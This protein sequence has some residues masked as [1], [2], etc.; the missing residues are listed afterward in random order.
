MTFSVKKTAIAPVLLSFCLAVMFALSSAGKAQAQQQAPQRPLGTITAIQGNAISLKTDSG[1]QVIVQ[2]QDS[3]RMVRVEPGQKTLQGA[4]LVHL[5]DLQV[6]DRI[7]ARGTASEDSKSLMAS[8]IILMKHSDIQQKQ[9]QEEEAWLRGVGGLVKTVDT[10]A[11]IITLSTGAGPTAKVVTIHASKATIVRRYAPASV[12]FSDAT[13][14]TLNQIKPG[15]QLRVRGTKSA[16]GSEVTADEIVS[17][18]FRNIAG[19]VVSTDPAANEITVMD[20]ITKK[21][22]VVKVTADSQLRKL[23]PMVAQMIALRL[24]GGA[25]PGAPAAANGTAARG[26]G[27]GPASAPASGQGQWAHG[28]AGGGTPSGIGAPGGWRSAGGTPDFQQMLSR[29]PAATL[30]DL[31][32]GDAVMIVS[33]EG[34]G[35]V[36]AL[37]LLS[38]VEPI[39]TASPGGGQSAAAALMSGW[40][41]GGGGAEGGDEGGQGPG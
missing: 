34:A 25:A 30:A 14:G 18:S 35:S 11:G 38:G 10:A 1:S 40:T 36:S 29:M 31:Q 7:L 23:P 15:D 19:T 33:S 17:G 41:L 12:K 39:L 27:G 24:K 16:D 4:T 13:A 22:V 9:R 28:G 32:K 8:S 3:T 5:Q 26:S 37:T 2:V 21:P 6:G 20:L